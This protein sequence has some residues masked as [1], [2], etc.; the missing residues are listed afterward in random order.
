MTGLYSNREK[1]LYTFSRGMWQKLYLARVLLPDFP[2][3]ILDEP[4]LGL[5]VISQKKL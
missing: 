1:R 2:L 3:I 5:D 4:W